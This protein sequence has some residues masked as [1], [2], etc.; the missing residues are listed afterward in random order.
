[1][2][3]TPPIEFTLVAH[4]VVHGTHMES[5][6]VAMSLGNSVAWYAWM[7]FSHAPNELFGDLRL[8][9]GI[10][11][12][13]VVVSEDYTHFTFSTTDL[14]KYTLIPK[15]EMSV[16]IGREWQDVKSYVQWNHV[17]RFGPNEAYVFGV[18]ACVAGKGDNAE[19]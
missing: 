16:Y 19:E 6:P 12:S 11:I 10:E 18:R 14:N 4:D 13:Q 2:R 7:S 15:S 5:G 17:Q 8:S 1:M 9:W 3:F